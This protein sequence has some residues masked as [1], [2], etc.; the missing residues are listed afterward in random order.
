MEK[1]IYF[2]SYDNRKC[3]YF[4]NL[5]P[6]KSNSRLLSKRWNFLQTDEI[7]FPKFDWQMSFF[8]ILTAGH[9]QR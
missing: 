9:C 4:Y 6:V 3:Y 8:Y 2:D 7:R 5:T 1:E